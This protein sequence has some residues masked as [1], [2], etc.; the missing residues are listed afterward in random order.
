MLNNHY[1]PIEFGI[2]FSLS[3]IALSAGATLADY[4]DRWVEQC[5]DFD[6]TKAE[7][8][9]A[10]AFSLFPPETV[11]VEVLQK[12][13]AAIGR[14]WFAGEVSVQQEHFASALANRK[15]DALI[16]ALPPPTRPGKIM[17]GCP[18]HEE[19]TFAARLLTF[20]LRRRGWEI[21]FLG[22]NVPLDRMTAMVAKAKLRGV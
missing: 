7:Q 15:V 20:L 9:L 18:P 6:E 4:R 2:H 11:G 22:A 10:Q 17:I 16:A 13:L 3:P 19:H 12:G 21:I 5:L 8:L 1:Q 14:L